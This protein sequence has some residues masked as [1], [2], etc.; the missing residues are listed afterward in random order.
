MAGNTGERLPLTLTVPPPVTVP[1]STSLM[2]PPL[3]SGLLQTKS[4][5]LYVSKRHSSEINFPN[6]ASPS[7]YASSVNSSGSN[8]GR[9]DVFHLAELTDPSSP[10][11]HSNSNRDISPYSIGSRGSG[12]G[13]EWDKREVK[14][15][16]DQGDLRNS[17]YY[18]NH[19]N[20]S[21][22]PEGSAS[23]NVIQQAIG[24]IDSSH[25]S[26]AGSSMKIR[27]LLN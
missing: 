19:S 4:K 1:S 27:D 16:V 21:M 10:L 3:S 18:G 9:Y 15:E 5:K 8:S 12:P 22:S 6:L 23:R 25:S 11:D 2:T 7:A 26:M 14:M 17:Y 20:H 13:S 24:E